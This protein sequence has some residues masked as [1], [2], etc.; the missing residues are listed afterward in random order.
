MKKVKKVKRFKG[1][2]ALTRVR[3]YFPDVETVV[4]AIGPVTV[5]VTK[6]D[7]STSKR[8]AHAECAMAVACKRAMKLDGVIIST[9]IAYLIK[10]TKATRYHVPPSVAREVVAFDRGANFESGKY[11][12]GTPDYRLA[13][14]HKSTGPHLTTKEKPIVYRHM[15]TNVRAVLGSDSVR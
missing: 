4:D 8:K 7:V 6:N 1:S 5:E 13:E 10:G 12:L 15:T 2:G 11:Q 3:K 9:A 14:T